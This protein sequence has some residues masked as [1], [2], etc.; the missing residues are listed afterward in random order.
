MQEVQ[1][2]LHVARE[3]NVE[4]PIQLVADEVA[5]HAWLLCFDEFHVTDVADAMI[6]GRLFQALFARGVVVVATSN[7]APDD[8]YKDG[9]NRQVFLPFIR[10]LKEQVDIIELETPRDFRQ[11]LAGGAQ[12]YFTPLGP[13]A[14][15]AMDEAWAR[16]TGGEAGAPLTLSVHG[17]RMPL[18]QATEDAARASFE[19]LCERPLGP[20]D[21]LEMA[22]RFRVVFID[23][24]PKLTWAQNNEAHRFVTLIDAL[25]EARARLYC[26]AETP[27]EEIYTEGKGAFEFSRTASRLR[28]MQSAAWMARTR[29]APAAGE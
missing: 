7:R 11:D 18:E 15:A 23:G 20:S 10:L 19:D 2:G 29:T 4:D 17:R 16:E 21:Y 8:L 14:D 26:S 28:E 12:T 3:T 6:L 9:L 27:P 22:R 24:I 5:E 25:Y 1:A 13:E